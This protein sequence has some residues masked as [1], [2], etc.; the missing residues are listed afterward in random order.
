MWSVHT[1]VHVT[2]DPLIPLWICHWIAL[3][4]VFLLSCGPLCVF[5][6]SLDTRFPTMWHFTS[7]DSDEPVQTPLSLKTPNVVQSIV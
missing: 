3:L 7:V 6:M 2:F 5:K 4:N 1:S